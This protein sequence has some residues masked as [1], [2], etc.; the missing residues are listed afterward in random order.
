MIVSAMAEVPNICAGPF[1]AVYSFYIERPRLMQVIGRTIWG[2]D[3]SVLY[4]AMAPIGELGEGRTIIDVPCG[5]GVA[6][7]AL[8]PGSGVRYVASDLSPAML[9][10]ARR[11]AAARGL[12]QIEFVL[13]D[14]TALPFEDAIADLSLSLS[15]LHMVDDPHA[16]VH[17]LVRCTRPGGRVLGTT[18]LA[19]G[20]RRSRIA[21]ALGARQGHPLPPARTELLAW[22][23]DAGLEDSFIGP[24]ST[25]ATFGGRKPDAPDSPPPTA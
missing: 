22:L 5:N 10:R 16:A 11:R 20:A 1:G 15:G 3:A 8:Q 12:E 13:A 19:G 25:F 18:F 21:F 17:E 9:D 6:F 24:Q 23:E 2:I 14:M 4:E 7:R